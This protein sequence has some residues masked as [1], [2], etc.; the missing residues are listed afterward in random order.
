MKPKS[1][2]KLRSIAE[3]TFALVEQTGLSGLTMASIAKAAGMATSTLYVYYPSKDALISEL[4]QAAKT[5]TAQRLM[6]G[7]PEAP[8]LRSKVRCIWN[9][10]LRNRLDHYAEVVLQEQYYN[11]PWFTQGS[12]ELVSKLF[13]TF[14]ALLE[15]G[16]R[17]EQLKAV[18]PIMLTGCLF[19][20]VRETAS[21]IRNQTMAGDEVTLSM[22]FSLC[23]DGIKA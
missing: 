8:T 9:N 23:W 3:A 14:F 12:R 21:L 2:D 5:A 6:E 22:A 13:A 10:M 18:P 4:Y 7:V 17:Q 16:Q 19:G 20:S 1:D 15:E 11:S